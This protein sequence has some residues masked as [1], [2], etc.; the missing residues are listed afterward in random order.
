MAALAG[1]PIGAVARLVLSFDCLK[2]QEEKAGFQVEELSHWLGPASKPST[3]TPQSLLG[4]N[5]RYS[6]V[7]AQAPM[8]GPGRPPVIDGPPTNILEKETEAK[9]AIIVGWYGD[10]DP[11]KPHNWSTMKKG[12]VVLIINLASF[13]IYMASAIYTPSQP[14][15]QKAFN[16]SVTHSTLGLGVFI[17][18]YGI[19]PLLWSPLSEIPTIGRNIPYIIS[20]SIF[21]IISVPTALSQ[22]MEVLLALR[23]LQGFF[24]SPVLSTGGASLSDIADSYTRPYALYTWAIGSLAGPCVGTVVAGY[25]VPRLGWRWSLWEIL[26]FT[27]PVG[28]LLVRLPLAI[29]FVCK[30]LSR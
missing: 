19:G 11:A 24:G 23:F 3:P 22:S 5:N 12:V 13:A 16:I 30:C 27:A 14:G 28:I 17:L 7:E 10:D 9:G 2:Y 8:N 18:G 20:I 6:D 29:G 1:T 26:F 21:I 25:T 4:A 15:I